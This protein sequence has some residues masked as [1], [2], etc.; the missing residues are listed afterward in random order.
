MEQM[1][2]VQGYVRDQSVKTEVYAL[3]VATLVGAA[4]AIVLTVFA[5]GSAATSEQASADE[6]AA[7]SLFGP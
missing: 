2:V 6:P 5:L 7:L 4:L 3:P 1:G